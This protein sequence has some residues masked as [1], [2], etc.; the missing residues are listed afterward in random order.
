MRIAKQK[1]CFGCPCFNLV[2]S[3][4]NLTDTQNELP[5]D[6]V[7][8]DCPL[9]LASVPECHGDLIDRNALKYRF[10]QIYHPIVQ[11]AGFSRKIIYKEDIDK[12]PVIIKSED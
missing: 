5:C 10:E 4:C 3:Y 1:A 2:G 9:P 6:T 8:P 7:L 12:A 11:R